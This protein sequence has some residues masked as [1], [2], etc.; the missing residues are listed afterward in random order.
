MK[1][2]DNYY[3]APF[4]GGT[5]FM[6]L[7][8]FIVFIIMIIV[9]LYTNPFV[10]VFLILGLIF[11]IF[12]FIFVPRGYRITDEGIIIIRLGSNIRIPIYEIAVIDY[13][14][15]MWWPH[16]NFFYGGFF[17]YAGAMYKSRYGW[18]KVYS[19]RLTRMVF[20]T[21]VYKNY[22]LIAP[23]RP[24]NFVEEVEKLMTDREFLD[25]E[26]KEPIEFTY[27][28]GDTDEGEFAEVI[29]Y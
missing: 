21:T 27:R 9:Y 13:S 16:I 20:I 17:G 2:G 28:G 19:K 22:F 26:E 18:M 8:G 5:V 10:A 1:E 24:E 7:F 14:R 23:E 15:G 11:S 4:G 3:K 25:S 12:G 6:M 29:D